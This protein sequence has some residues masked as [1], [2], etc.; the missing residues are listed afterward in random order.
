MLYNYI[1]LDCVAKMEDAKGSEL[2][3][4]EIASIAFEVSHKM[5]AEEDEIKPISVCPICASH[6]TQKSI[7]GYDVHGYVAGSGFLDK[8]GCRKEINLYKLTEKDE[9]G[10]TLDPY[11]E[12][13]EPG[14]VDDLKVRI[15]RQGKA[16]PKYFS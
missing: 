6:N 1:C 16:K 5:F 2:N 11:D 10:V 13:R 14:E 8:A 12:Y 7:N 15:K 9:N 3:A 4:S